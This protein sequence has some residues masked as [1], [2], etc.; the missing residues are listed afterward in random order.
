MSNG[1]KDAKQAA[2]DTQKMIWGTWFFTGIVMITLAILTED[3][4]L[5]GPVLDFVAAWGWIPATIIAIVLSVMVEMRRD[6]ARKNAN[7]V[8]F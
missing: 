3:V 5:L 8:G 4:F 2:E 1:Y 6:D 7:G